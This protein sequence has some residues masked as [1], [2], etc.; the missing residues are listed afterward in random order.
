MLEKCQRDAV[1]LSTPKQVMGSLRPPGNLIVCHLEFGGHRASVSLC[2]EEV[3][4]KMRDCDEYRP[5]V[6]E[7]TLRNSL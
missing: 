1:L 3:F 6:A 5:A 2:P 4:L 7:P